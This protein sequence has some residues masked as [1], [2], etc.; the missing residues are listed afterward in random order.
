MDRERTAARQL[1]EQLTKARQDFSELSV[2]LKIKNGELEEL[3][4]RVWSSQSKPK[5]DSYRRVHWDTSDA[6]PGA[7]PPPQQPQSWLAFQSDAAAAGPT[8]SRALPQKPTLSCALLQTPTQS[9]AAVSAGEDALQEIN[10]MRLKKMAVGKAY[11]SKMLRRWDRKNLY[12]SFA[13]WLDSIDHKK[14]IQR[15]ML[16][17][18]GRGTRASLLRTWCAWFDAV[19]ESAQERPQAGPHAAAPSAAGTPSI[20]AAL[21]NLKQEQLRAHQDLKDHHKEEQEH[22]RGEHREREKEVRAELQELHARHSVEQQKLAQM[23][24]EEVKEMKATVAALRYGN[25]RGCLFPFYEGLF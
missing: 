23:H 24:R 13:R 6:S 19:D 4:A 7:W 16:K 10:L 8:L 21:E 12:H 14:R 18:C 1:R 9:W 17:V 22:L 3:Q 11:S 25:A 20:G 15:L 5:V 2:L